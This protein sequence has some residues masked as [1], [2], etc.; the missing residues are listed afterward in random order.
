MNVNLED[1]AFLH[2]CAKVGVL[3]HLETKKWA[4]KHALEAVLT[5]LRVDH[6]IMAKQAGG[7]DN[8]RGPGD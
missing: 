4:I 5:V 8:S 7:P 1:E 6:I 3:D 2:D